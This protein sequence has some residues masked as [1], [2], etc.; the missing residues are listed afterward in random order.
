MF[1]VI[2]PTMFKCI[3]I[4]N[5]LLANLYQDP[6]VSEV[7]LI[8]NT[9][10]YNDTVKLLYN[11]K[12]KIKP[13]SKNIY[14]NPAWNLGVSIAKEDYIAIINDDITI[15]E[16]VFT[17]LSQASIENLGVIGANYLT[18]QEVQIPKRFVINEFNLVE[19]YQRTWGFG[20]F[21]VMYKNHYENIPEELKI[22]CGD[23][24]IY[25]QNR[26]SGRYNYITTFPI[27]TKMS[28]TSDNPIFD[29]LKNKD[30][31]I[32]NLKY[33]KTYNDTRRVVH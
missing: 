1:S 8:D 19:V 21:M 32:Y 17:G 15:P 11:D 23:D 6:F 25:Q 3:N 13:Q 20:I 5:E 2:I 31:E 28:T 24:Y 22:W 7:I 16:N 30:L 29:E 33:K 26:L 10:N 27:Q 4:T 9:E 18:I 12:L 14:V